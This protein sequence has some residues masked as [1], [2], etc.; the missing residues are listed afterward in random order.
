MCVC[1]CVCVRPC[2]F[3]RVRACVPACV[4]Q[5]LHQ[6]ISH[7]STLMC[8]GRDLYNVVRSYTGGGGGGGG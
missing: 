3:L 7:Q 8:I 6:Q 2:V 1:V 4:C 5:G